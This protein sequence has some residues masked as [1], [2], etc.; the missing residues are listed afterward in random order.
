MSQSW[1]RPIWASAKW[2]RRSLLKDLEPLEAIRKLVE[3]T[4]DYYVANPEFIALVNQEN[5]LGAV[6]LKKSGIV[7]RRTSVLLKRVKAILKK[8]VEQG[9][10]R[11]GI[12]PLQLNHSVAGLGFYYLNNRFTNSQ[13]YNFDHMTQKALWQSDVPSS[14]TS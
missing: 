11:P 7:K 8:G 13:I 12:D 5:L 4:W 6:Y 9:K 10:I 14:S 1:S 2:R 3:S